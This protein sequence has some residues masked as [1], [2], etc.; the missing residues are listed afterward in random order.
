MESALGVPDAL[1]RSARTFE[2]S[3]F[4]VKMNIKD[5]LMRELTEAKK[6]DDFISGQELAERCGVTRTAVWKA[7]NSLRKQGAKI[8]AVTNRGYRLEDSEIFNAE[9]VSAKIPAGLGV[10]IVYFRSI[11]S[12]NTEAKKRLALAESGALHKTVFVA[13]M[14]TAGRG[15][16]AGRTFYSPAENGVYLSLV[17]NYGVITEPA[18]ITALAA[19]AVCRALKTVYGADAAIKWVN[20]IYL[21]GK[22]VCGILTEGSANFESGLIESAV[23]GIGLNISDEGLPD[24]LKSVAGGVIGEGDKRRRSDA[25]AAI[26]TEL[27]NLLEGDESATFEAMREY[28]ARSN[29]IGKTVTVSPVIGE[30][31]TNYTCVVTGITDDA[32]LAVRLADG[33][34][35]HLD[36]GEVSVLAAENRV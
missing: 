15:R 34:E 30:D 6:R 21:R 9:A 25:A 26:I 2:K 3:K 13:A 24:E 16:L 17:W 33:T 7:V 8:E 20:D 29:L 31:K 1:I 36:S 14:Q 27:V 28:K 12:T 19:V 11:D 18:R 10:K 22:K 23:I 4:E 32:K 35:R 5:L